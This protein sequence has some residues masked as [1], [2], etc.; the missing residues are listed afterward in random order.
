MESSM[1]VDCCSVSK[2]IR[3]MVFASESNAAE[4]T[5]SVEDAAFGPI[6]TTQGSQDLKELDPTLFNS[7]S[8][9]TVAAVG[10]AIDSSLGSDG[11][12]EVAV[13]SIM[14]LGLP[15]LRR[16]LQEC[17]CPEATTST[18]ETT[19]EK[20]TSTTT[21]KES[22]KE[23]TS[24][25]AETEKTENAE[26]ENQAPNGLRKTK[27]S[28]R[29]LRAKPKKRMMQAGNGKVPLD[30]EISY[31]VSV[32][33]QQTEEDKSTN[34]EFA[35]KSSTTVDNGLNLGSMV[36]GILDVLAGGSSGDLIKTLLE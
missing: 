8:T 9:A 30:F 10:N 17:S 14:L 28:L 13:S 1:T 34:I 6:Q 22:S 24:A 7:L 11:K 20:E 3:Q 32:E 25:T 5:P 2:E 12:E 31:V 21:E 23:S 35:D 19:T 27:R 26:E 16:R 18:I 36:S 4:S 29:G 15:G 33:E